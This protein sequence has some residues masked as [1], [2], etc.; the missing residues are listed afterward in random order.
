MDKDFFFV[1][2]D[3]EED[4]FTILEKVYHILLSPFVVVTLCFYLFGTPL[5]L[6]FFGAPLL[7][8]CYILRKSAL[9]CRKE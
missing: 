3:E 9:N 7:L 5:L 2:E 1:I 4:D 8:P 6:S